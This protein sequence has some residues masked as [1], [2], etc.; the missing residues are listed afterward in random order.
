MVDFAVDLFADDDTMEKATCIKQWIALLDEASLK[1]GKR[2]NIAHNHK[3]WMIEAG[4]KN[5]TEEVY[6]VC[7]QALEIEIRG[8]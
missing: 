7:F 8:E 2:L 6:K 1:F 3:Q 5:V 4:F